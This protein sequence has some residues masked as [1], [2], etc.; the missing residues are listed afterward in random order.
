M[1]VLRLVLCIAQSDLSRQ[2]GPGSLIGLLN[3]TIR[4]LRTSLDIVTEQRAKDQETT[5]VSAFLWT[6]WSRILLLRLRA[7]AGMQLQGFDYNFRG[8]S[9]IRFLDVVP[10]IAECRK[11]IQH[12]ELQATPYLCAWAYRNLTNDRA[13]ISTDLRRFH[14]LYHACFGARQAVCNPG[15]TQCDGWSSVACGRFEHTPVTNQSCHEPGCPGDC[16]RLFWIRESFV[17]ISGP[18][19]V[20]I[21]ATDATGLPYY[22]AAIPSENDLRWDCIANITRIFSVSDTTLVCDRDIMTID[23][24]D[25]T[26]DICEKLLAAL[27]VCDWN[28]RAWTLLEA[29]R[30]RNALYLLCRDDMVIS[31]RDALQ[32]VY[33]SGRI[34]MVIPFMMRSYLLPPNDLTDMELFEGGGSVA[35]EED[36]QIAKGFISIGE[37]AVLLSHRHATRDDDDL[38]I[39]NLLAGDMETSDP[40]DMWR[41]R[42][43]K[44][45]STEALV[46]S[47]PRLRGVPGF[48]WAPSRPTMPRRTHTSVLSSNGKEFP[49]FE[50]VDARDGYVTVDGLR[51]KWLTF[52]FG[53][54]IPKP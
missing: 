46:S 53:V 48:H 9:S 54:S 23:I 44:K 30:G 18:K 37:A 45:I 21:M 13:C 2:Y 52:E 1:I 20:D 6:S 40:A 7:V 28:M 15:S 25:H 22:T 10:E 42:I 26:V 29:M 5:I 32:T 14:Q 47:C 39:W 11:R 43:G 51:A 49:P 4:V 35:T 41:R 12:K 34:D 24:S 50:G 16:R 33:T 19:A 8:L 27:L 36:L 31:V 17:S 38:L 3:A